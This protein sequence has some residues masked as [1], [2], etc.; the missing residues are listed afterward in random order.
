MARSVVTMRLRINDEY[1]FFALMREVV[2]DLIT[3][4]TS[5]QLTIE[6]VKRITNRFLEKHFS[7][8]EAYDEFIEYLEATKQVTLQIMQ[9]AQSF[10]TDKWIAIYHP[11]S[12]AKWDEFYTDWVHGIK[13]RLIE[14]RYLVKQYMLPDLNLPEEK[15]SQIESILKRLDD[16]KSRMS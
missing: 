10:H 7:T 14:L 5:M 1:A 15:T 3:Q 13:R 9:F 16:F 12:E 8:T 11:Y 4:L 2:Y 6:I